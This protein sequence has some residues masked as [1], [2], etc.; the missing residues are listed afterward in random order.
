MR[1]SMHSIEGRTGLASRS[2]REEVVEPLLTY[3]GSFY[4][5]LRRALLVAIVL[6]A[7]VALGAIGSLTL[8]LRRRWQK[9]ALTV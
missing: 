9:R 2:V 4:S 8:F 6:R 1:R 5:A 7:T 3:A